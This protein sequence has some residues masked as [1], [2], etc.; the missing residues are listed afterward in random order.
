[1]ASSLPT[2]LV[3]LC[4]K[5]E[6][7]FFNLKLK[8]IFCKFDLRFLDLA[9]FHEKRL[10]VVWRDG[11]P[12]GCCAKCLRLTAAFER[13]NYACCSVTGPG[14][15]TLLNKPLTE[16]TIR[17][18]HCFALLDLIE[19]CEHFYTAKQFFLVRG[20]WRGCCRNCQSYE[21]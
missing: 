1:M 10:C 21:G 20:H 16:I 17:C 19:K 13:E 15:C 18:I 14:I 5:F 3:D 6:T 2:N 9:G 7:S 8:C 4:S 12:F 11:E